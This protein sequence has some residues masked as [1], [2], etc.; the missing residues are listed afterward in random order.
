MGKPL[1]VLEVEHVARL[2]RE[3]VPLRDIA[4]SMGISE[5]SAWDAAKGRK[6]GVPLPPHVYAV[7]PGC[8]L[9]DEFDS[10]QK[11]NRTQPFASQVSS[12]CDDCMP[13]WALEVRSQ[14]INLCDGHPA[15]VEDEEPE[16]EP[17]RDPVKVETMRRLW[18]DQG[19]RVAIARARQRESARR[20]APVAQT[21]RRLREEGWSWARIGDHLGM[22]PSTAHYY[23][24]G[25]RRDREE[26]VA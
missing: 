5:R 7:R 18:S 1:T 3:G 21:I 11:A 8:M 4:T 17:M 6:S 12:P 10:W 22:R 9:P 20:R 14:P 19:Y 24:H 15:G 26:S 16:P 13:A 23:L 2:Y 25:H